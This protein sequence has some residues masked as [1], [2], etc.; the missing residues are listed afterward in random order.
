[1]TF[2]I[3]PRSPETGYGY[4]RKGEPADADGTGFMVLEFVEKPDA[5]TA[6]SY[7]DSG[8]Y[9]WNSGMFLFRASRYLRNWGGIGR[10]YWLHAKKRWRSPPT[11]GTSSG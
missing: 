4:I 2:G 7:L 11:T 3:V 1:M 8:D 9:L 6:Q 5:D 10:T